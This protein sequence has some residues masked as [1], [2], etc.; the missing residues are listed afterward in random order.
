MS[1]SAD[2]ARSSTDDGEGDAAASGD[3]PLGEAVGCA[4]GPGSTTG[5]G[6]VKACTS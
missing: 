4:V 2:V 1:G 6:G 5:E 3:S